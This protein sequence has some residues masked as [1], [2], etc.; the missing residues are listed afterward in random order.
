[1]FINRDYDALVG[2]QR[3]FGAAGGLARAWDDKAAESEGDLEGRDEGFAA[4]V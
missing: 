4:S 3:D 2:S 1:M